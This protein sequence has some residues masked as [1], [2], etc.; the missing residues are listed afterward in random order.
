MIVESKG[1]QLFFFALGLALCASGVYGLTDLDNVALNFCRSPDKD[2]FLNTLNQ[3]LTVVML[4]V[5]FLLG[6]LCDWLAVHSVRECRKFAEP[7]AFI[8]W[9]GIFRSVRAYVIMISVLAGIVI[10]LNTYVCDECVD[11]SGAA[12]QAALLQKERSDSTRVHCVA[13]IMSFTE[14][15]KSKSPHNGELETIGVAT[16]G[17]LEPLPRKGAIMTVR[18]AEDDTKAELWRKMGAVIQFT[19]SLKSLKNGKVGDSRDILGPMSLERNG[20]TT[21]HSPN[22]PYGKDD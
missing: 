16:L 17:I 12:R 21:A 10:I 22:R 2:S 7:R 11:P 5:V 20:E 1:A 9:A 8:D 13:K 19:I 6:I 14:S 4:C 3:I 18:V 15:P